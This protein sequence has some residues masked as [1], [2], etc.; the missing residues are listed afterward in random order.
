MAGLGWAGRS[1]YEQA[2]SFSSNSS[3]RG[4]FSLYGL[5]CVLKIIVKLLSYKYT[6]SINVFTNILQ[7]SMSSIL[8]FPHFFQKEL[9]FWNSYINFVCIF[10]YKFFFYFLSFFF[11]FLHFIKNCLSCTINIT[12]FQTIN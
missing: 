6:L 7:Y 11:H 8:P 9:Y 12:H 3:I 1:L 10:Q 5:F 2:P 4:I